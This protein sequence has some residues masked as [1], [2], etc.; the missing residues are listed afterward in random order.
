MGKATKRRPKMSDTKLVYSTVNFPLEP[1]RIEGEKAEAI[2]PVPGSW[3]LAPDPLLRRGIKALLCCPNC[4]QAA[5]ITPSMGE[6]INGV[7]ELKAFSCR[8]CGFLC[9]AR[10]QGWDTKKLY[11]IAYKVLD[12]K[13]GAV[14]VDKAGEEIRK[15]Y[16]HGDSREQVFMFFVEGRKTMGRFVIVDVAPVIG[17]FGKEADKDQ[18]D[19]TV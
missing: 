8:Q 3:T 1:W 14:L 13:S 6:V 10:L 9:D 2:W 18:K 11:C 16:T 7:C 17:F 19:L 15:E 4:K 12:E 5:L